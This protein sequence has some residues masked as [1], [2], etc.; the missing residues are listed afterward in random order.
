ML[1]LIRVCFFQFS[2]YRYHFKFGKMGSLIERE[3]D[4][5]NLVVLIS[6]A[7]DAL[8][9]S[10]SKSLNDGTRKELSQACEHLAS[11]LKPPTKRIEDLTYAVR[12]LDYV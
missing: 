8:S 12:R 6:Q 1:A 7:A 11:Q 2:T 3:L 4:Y 9:D 10:K 5:S